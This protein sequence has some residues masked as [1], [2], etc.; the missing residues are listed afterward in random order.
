MMSRA[1]KWLL[2][3]FA[4]LVSVALLVPLCGCVPG[5]QFTGDGAF[6]ANTSQ[7]FRE[8]R[9]Y[10]LGQEVTMPAETAPGTPKDMIDVRKLLPVYQQPKVPE[11]NISD[12]SPLTVL[13]SSVRIPECVSGPID[14]AVVLDLYTGMETV[15]QVTSLVV[16]YQR[17]V[18]GGMTLAFQNLVVFSTDSWNSDSPPLFRLRLVDV[19][20]ERNSAT[21]SF[22]AQTE[23]LANTF[24]DVIPSP[25]LPIVSIAM[26]AA[27][28]ILGNEQNKVIIDYTVQFFGASFVASLNGR[29]SVAS[30]QR[31][32]WMVVGLPQGQASRFWRSRLVLD[33]RTEE[34]FDE[35]DIPPTNPPIGKGQASYNLGLQSPYITMTTAP[36]SAQVYGLVQ[37]RSEALMRLLTSK[38]PRTAEEVT[39]L[40]NDLQK[41]LQTFV[42][43]RQLRRER[44]VAAVRAIFTQVRL[45][46]NSVDSAALIAELKRVWPTNYADKLQPS[47]DGQSGTWWD[48]HNSVLE[49]NR[50]KYR[51]IAKDGLQ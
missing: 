19:K 10:Y 32:A 31:G 47:I 4:G 5:P 28:L 50:D 48:T 39:N 23:Q 49:F 34:L 51:L 9:V 22:L 43:L 44:T 6:A 3:A 21:V 45:N 26:K 14:V 17:D 7:A 12:G 27:K 24:S 11:D 36:Y 29:A 38:G 16:W 13:V 42:L 20:A 2:S 40:S 46:R 18:V 33:Q 15:D 1:P 30:L 8:N 41:S 37:Q 35:R 25:A